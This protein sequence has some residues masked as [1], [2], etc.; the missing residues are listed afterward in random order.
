MTRTA[1]LLTT[2]AA[3][4]TLAG[5]GAS[6]ASAQ[7]ADSVVTVSPRSVVAA[8]PANSPIDFAGVRTARRGRPLPADNV[9][10]GRKVAITRGSEV[11]Y[12][13]LTLRCPAD[14]PRLRS[15]GFTGQVAPQVLFPLRYV[16][17]RAVNVMV[18]YNARA[19]PV[20]GTAQGTV[21]ALCR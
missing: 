1:R 11:A 20:G 17:K 12:G 2:L 19:I 21:L 8:A 9:V 10:I 18:T 3:A 4:A 16:G 14:H 7:S 5:A 15:L 13:A 6:A